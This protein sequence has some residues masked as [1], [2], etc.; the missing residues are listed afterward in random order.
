MTLQSERHVK[1]DNQCNDVR[2]E[3]TNPCWDP[4]TGINRAC[5]RFILLQYRGKRSRVRLQPQREQHTA[6]AVVQLF[7]Q[8]A[9][10]RLVPRVGGNSQNCRQFRASSCRRVA[11]KQCKLNIFSALAGI[12][13]RRLH[14]LCTMPP[15]TPQHAHHVIFKHIRFVVLRRAGGKYA[16]VLLSRAASVFL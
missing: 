13:T 8:L 11:S 9:S 16:K 7:K 4:F 1:L 15:P 6:H 10:E 12:L 14:H 5:Y 2:A 3:P